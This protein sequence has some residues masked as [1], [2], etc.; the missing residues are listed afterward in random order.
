M[1]R[2]NATLHREQF[3]PRQEFATKQQPWSHE[4]MPNIGVYRVCQHHLKQPQKNRRN[5]T[6]PRDNTCQSLGLIFTCNKVLMVDPVVHPWKINGWVPCPHGGLESDHF[7]FCTWVV[8]RFQSWILQGCRFGPE[9]KPPNPGE[10]PISID[11]ILLPS[12]AALFPNMFFGDTSATLYFLEA[13]L[14][15]SPYICSVWSTQNGPIL[16]SLDQTWSQKIFV[17]WKNDELLWKNY[18]VSVSHSLKTLGVCNVE[19]TL[20]PE[21]ALPEILKLPARLFSPEN[22]PNH[23]QQ[24]KG[25]HFRLPTIFWFK[26][27]C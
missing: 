2:P 21:T 25:N 10:T 24:R 6:S 26:T 23:S 3:W 8:C 7:S 20:S 18:H 11:P 16:W 14:W 17:S 19:V 15:T 13:N 9:S 12:V 27:C 1:P 4:V 22:R 5:P